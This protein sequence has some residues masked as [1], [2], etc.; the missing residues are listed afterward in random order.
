MPS[1]GGEYFFFR[2][3]VAPL[4]AFVFSEGTKLTLLGDDF[5]VTGPNIYWLGLDENVVCVLILMERTASSNACIYSPNPSY[6]SRIRVLDALAAV[7]VCE[8]RE[9]SFILTYDPVGYG[10][11]D[12]SCPYAWRFCWESIERRTVFRRVQ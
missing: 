8:Y 12:S 5:R 4:I 3:F 1:L 6:P 11:D 2:K 7:Y 10:W 9:G